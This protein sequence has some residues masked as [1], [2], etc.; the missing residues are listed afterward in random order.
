P[1]ALAFRA[2][3]RKVTHAVMLA[4]RPRPGPVHLEVPLRKPLE[5]VEPATDAE[6]ALAATRAT[7]SPPAWPPSLAAEPDALDA[8]AAAIAG[9]S[10]RG[11]GA[12]D[13]VARSRRDGACRDRRRAGG[14]DRR[15]GRSR[16]VQSR[17][18]AI[19]RLHARLARRRCARGV[20]ARSRD[21][22]AP[23]QRSRGD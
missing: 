11:L 19:Q 20:G 22:I 8:L 18:R 23:A 9:A 7:A 2:M 17:R 3:R 6:L 12:R 1:T 13:R 15:A 21:R 4:R 10:R 16:V 14:V 5:P